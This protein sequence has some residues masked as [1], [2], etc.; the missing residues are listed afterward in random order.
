MVTEKR[1]DR[2]LVDTL[3]KGLCAKVISTEQSVARKGVRQ[4][5]EPV[6][7]GGC[8]ARCFHNG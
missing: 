2:P 3:C 4:I 5:G 6:I 1:N 7:T 8:A